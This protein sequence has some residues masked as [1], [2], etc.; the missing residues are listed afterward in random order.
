LTAADRRGQITQLCERLAQF[1]ET[2]ATD[3]LPKGRW[4]LRPSPSSE[5]NWGAQI[6]RSAIALYATIHA[7]D[8]TIGPRKIGILVCR[9]RV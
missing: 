6:G 9:N 4:H 7:D 3:Q 8:G 2:A 5:M 1:L